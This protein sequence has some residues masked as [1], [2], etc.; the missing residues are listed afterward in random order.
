MFVPGSR[1]GGMFWWRV[2]LDKPGVAR[3][4]RAG[5]TGSEL[6]HCHTTSHVSFCGSDKARQSYYVTLFYF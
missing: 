6:T 1:W 4:D 3:L 5:L 2:G